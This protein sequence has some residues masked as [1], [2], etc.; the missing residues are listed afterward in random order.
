[1]QQRQPVIVQTPRGGQVAAQIASRPPPSVVSGEVVVEHPATDAE[2]RLEVID[3]GQALLSLPSPDALAREA[4]TVRRVIGQAG[5]GA[6]PVVLVLETGEELTE[7]QL[8][9]LLGAAAHTSRAVI[10][11]VIA[12]A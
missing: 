12:D 8:Q 11:R 3:A 5:R 7:E 2:G 4:D 10:L 9:V 1:M 6:Q